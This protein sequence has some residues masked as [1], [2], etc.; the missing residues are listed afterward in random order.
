MGITN[1]PVQLKF[2][3]YRLNIGKARVMLEWPYLECT[4]FANLITG[5][6]YR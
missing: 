5:L 2:V 6:L 4:N 1:T 3:A